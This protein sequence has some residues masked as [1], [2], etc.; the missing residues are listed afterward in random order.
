[1]KNILEENISGI[2]D[3]MNKKSFF[4]GHTV[5]LDYFNIKE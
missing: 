3:A 2:N 1:M 5:I 4:V